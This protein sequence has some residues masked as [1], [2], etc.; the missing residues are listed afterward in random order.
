MNEKFPPNTKVFIVEDDTFI[1]GLMVKKF[2][3]DGCTV[4]TANA[5][6]K[7]FEAIK[8][9]MPNV[10]LL[11][12]MLPGGVDGLGILQ[13]LKSEPTTKNIPVLMLSNLGE[14]PQIDQSKKLGAA[15]FLIKATMSVDEIAAE[16]MKALKK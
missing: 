1:S 15:S 2:T 11:D 10:I 6:D 14:K 16:A 8:A 7:A 9:A 4:T 3:A 12:I 13:Q 5:G